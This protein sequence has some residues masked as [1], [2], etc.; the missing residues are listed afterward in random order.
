MSAD[1]VPLAL[2]LE[3]AP[4]GRRIAAIHLPGWSHDRWHRHERLAAER[5]AAVPHHPPS[6]PG[7]VAPP[8]A[9]PTGP[10]VLYREHAHGPVIHGASPEAAALGLAPGDRLA[11]A[12]A[13][14]PGLRAVA[15]DEGGDRAALDRAVRWA[16]RWS[17]HARGALGG[18]GDAS[19]LLDTTGCDHLHGGEDAMAR[20]MR[21]RLGG[22]G[23]DARVTVAPTP[24]GALAL[25]MHGGADVRIVAAGDLAPTLAPLPVAALGLDGGTVTILR[26]LG[27]KS[28]GDLA[29]VPRAALK[30]RFSSRYGKGDRDAT[31]ED[32]MGR[33]TIRGT[34]PMIDPLRLLDL[35]HGALADPLVPVAE[36]PPVRA[37]AGLLEPI[38]RE[39]A[40]RIVL[41]RLLDELTGDLL[42]RGAGASELYLVGYR[43]DGGTAS[44]RVR[45]ARPTRDGAHWL[46]LFDERLGRMEAGPGFDAFALEAPRA[47]PM[48]AEQTAIGAPRGPDPAHALV[49]LVDALSGR[50]GEDRVLVPEPCDSHWPERAEAW[51]PA[52]GRVTE[53]T[54]AVRARGRGERRER[55][56]RGE[57]SSPG[58]D[59]WTPPPGTPARPERLFDPP[60]PIEV[61]YG[62]PDGP[63]SRFRWRR[64]PHRVVRHAG[65]E[66]IG[67]EWWRE[68]GSA[69]TR[70]YWRVED[71]TGRRFWL[72][73]AGLPGDGRGMPE[74]FCAGL[75]A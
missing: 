67:P 40:V 72:F 21:D 5:G 54:V 61:I 63:P 10:V 65:P 15:L 57:G 8:P 12:M 32:I 19:I 42:A 34:T 70:D 31:W 1:P 38:D 17:P 29:A 18:A 71:E 13:S 43:V 33:G 16:R 58:P 45:A 28:V 73:R 59:A 56:E 39:E 27:L 2:S 37:R 7:A 49:R 4:A 30:R 11:D 69:R 35:V 62:L 74:W 64:T 66:R 24:R 9:A 50:L 53:L 20:D 44:L 26:R 48:D 41:G 47:E 22:F 14:L 60:E 23:Y 46:R 75:F 25:A 55:E 6:G 36:E 68:P 52:M 3:A 51:V